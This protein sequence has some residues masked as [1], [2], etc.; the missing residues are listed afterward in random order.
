[1]RILTKL[2]IKEMLLP[3]AFL[4]IGLSVLLLAG[5]LIP[6]LPRILQDGIAFF[7]LLKLS[8]LLIPSLWSFVLPMSAL[9]SVLLGFLRLSRDSELIA[10]KA[11]GISP[12]RILKPVLIVSAFLTLIGLCLSL[13]LTPASKAASRALLFKVAQQGLIK[14]ITQ[15]GFYSPI[16]GITVYV[17]EKTDAGDLNGVF[18]SDA[19]NPNAKLEIVAQ[20]GKVATGSDDTGGSIIFSLRHG[21]LH[22]VD[23]SKAE[24]DML[25]FEGYTF[26]LAVKTEGFQPSRGSMEVA[27]LL[28]RIYDPV[29]GEKKYRLYS[30]EL[31]KR[32]HL[33]L[34]IGALCLIAFSLGCSFG[35]TGFSG[36]IAIGLGVF[37]A[38]YTL[39]T[40]MANIAEAGT[41]SPAISMLLVN[42]IFTG[43]GLGLLKGNMR[44]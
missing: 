13:A 41:I 6:L 19:R 31:Y 9:I 44:K 27:E 42:V 15:K 25:K 26:K 23:T 38:Y 35:K 3:F 28:K 14:G 10:A 21:S 39:F 7:S 8:C 12:L 37:L 29:T 18:I 34:G 36:G 22:R 2:V 5:Q 30:T 40:F 1:M 17:H 4:F 33:P 20:Q 32:I 11:C 24:V 43:I 16:D